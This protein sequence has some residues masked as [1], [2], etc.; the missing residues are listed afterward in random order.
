MLEELELELDD[1]LLDEVLLY[2]AGSIEFPYEPCAWHE[3]ANRP[4]KAS[5]SNRIVVAVL[6]ETKAN[7]GV[8]M[9]RYSAHLTA[10]LRTLVGM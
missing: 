3:H 6:L 2:A 10:K 5:A 4:T 8:E 1:T 7:V 9:G